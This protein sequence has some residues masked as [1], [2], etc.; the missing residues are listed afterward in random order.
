[1]PSGG[2]GKHANP[3]WLC[4]LVLIS[5][6]EV[7]LV[8]LCRPFAEYENETFYSCYLNADTAWTIVGSIFYYSWTDVGHDY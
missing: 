6:V 5:S 8:E 7:P 1:M 2:K 3:L 4:M